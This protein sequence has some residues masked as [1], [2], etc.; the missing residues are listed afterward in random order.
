MLVLCQA[1][2]Y[3]FENPVTSCLTELMVHR[4]DLIYRDYSVCQTTSLLAFGCFISRKVVSEKIRIDYNV[5]RVQL[6]NYQWK[7]DT[8]QN[9]SGSPFICRQILV[10]NTSPGHHRPGVGDILTF[11]A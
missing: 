9:K 4:H 11:S 2:M 3:F 7:N 6:R 8:V 1:S 5:G 10:D